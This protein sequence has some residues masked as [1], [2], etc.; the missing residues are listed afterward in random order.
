MTT[1]NTGNPLG[2]AAA[3]DLYDNAENFDHLSNDQVNEAWPDRFGVPRLTWHGMEMRYQEKLTSMGWSLIDSFQNGTT[4][5]RTDQALRWALPDGDGEYYRW[6]GVLPKNVP[7]NSTPETTGGIGTGAWLSVGDAALRS[8]L[9]K[10][11]GV[12]LVNG[13]LHGA[14]DSDP[15]I[16]FK[17]TTSSGELYEYTPG[18]TGLAEGFSVSAS[19]LYLTRNGLSYKYSSPHN[20]LVWPSQYLDKNADAKTS[21][22]AVMSHGLNIDMNGA[23]VNVS[24][25]NATKDLLN[26]EIVA[27]SD[28][29]SLLTINSCRVFNVKVNCNSK[30]VRRPIH[31]K[32]GSVNPVLRN[33]EV[34]DSAGALQ[35][36]AVF[37]D[38][39]DVK[40]FVVDGF[41]VRDCSAVANGTQGDADGPCRGVIVGTALDPYPTQETVSSGVIT[42]G[43]IYNLGP[44]EDCDG[45]VVQVYDSSA[46][47]LSAGKIKVHG[48]KTRNVLKRAVK[49]QANNVDVSDIF[50]QCDDATATNPMY[51]IVSVYGDQCTISNISGRGRINNGVDTSTGFNHVN[52]IFL[53]STANYE[54]GAG[55]HI[56]SGQVSASNIYSE[57]AR[58]VVYIR[59]VSAPTPFVSVSGIGGQ[60]YNG[61]VIMDMRNGFS[62]SSVHLNDIYATSSS[63]A[64]SSIS[65]D[66]TGGVIGTV[67]ITNVKR[68][69]GA[70]TS[71]D[72]NISGN[73]SKCYV[74]GAILDSGSS[75][76]GVA[77]ATGQLIAENISTNKV[78]AVQATQTT[79]SFINNID[80]QVRLVNT[81][82]TR[83]GLYRSISQ[84]GTNTGLAIVT[85]A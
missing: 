47:T 40:D 16:G 19:Q 63:T 31:I 23:S 13:A 60:G 30:A 79:D 41:I 34:F 65:I 4:L 80:G 51:S 83:D 27:I 7:V 46:N 70:N 77:M 78:Y 18:I 21:I 28:A 48:I 56:I 75:T 84:S 25:I 10:T 2:S 39:N 72:I 9:A 85:Y 36:S 1:Y 26:A 61:V 5:T 3:K 29:G 12:N 43:Y 68:L 35:V 33:F 49:I 55:L 81:T 24:N 58:Y 44:W 8:Q 73:V 14:M 64:R 45:V 38:C 69:S 37:V 32:A 76:V 66:A 50:V 62:I 52:N 11:G 71:S 82:N 57:G 74:R 15:N 54:D 53:K 42:N 17:I 59:A 22:E 20:T 67:N 6:D